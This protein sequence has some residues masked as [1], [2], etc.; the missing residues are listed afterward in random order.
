MGL[1][2]EF[3]N[4]IS[5]GYQDLTGSL[6]FTY[7]SLINIIIFAILLSI[8]SIFTW[9]FYRFI[10]KKDLIE[11]NLSKY[12][13]SNHPWIAKIFAAIL[14]LIEYIIILPFLIFFW[15]AI[16]SLLILIL[17][18][19]LVIN[20]VVVITASIVITIRIL[21]YY[22]EDLSRDL[23]KIFPFTIM[24]IFIL[25]PGFFSLERIGA[26]LL[27][28]PQLLGS[29]LYFL[30]LIV[31]VELFLRV[32]DLMINLASSDKETITLEQKPQQV[33]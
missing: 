9:K 6:S 17:S 20:Q 25:S 28:I 4:G 3:I 7:S 11:L 16:L 1:I 32:I 14:Y 33:N 31:A 15:F 8:Y 18:E 27:E 5:I 23:A 22:A 29:I 10:S 30:I 12:N 2:Q 26:N 19:E 13:R 24:V 21:S